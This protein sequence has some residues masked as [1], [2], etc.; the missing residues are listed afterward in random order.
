MRPESSANDVR[1][2]TVGGHRANSAGNEMHYMFPTTAGGKSGAMMCAAN[3]FD[4]EVRSI[5]L[6]EYDDTTMV[7]I[8][9]TLLQPGLDQHLVA[10]VLQPRLLLPDIYCYAATPNLPNLLTGGGDHCFT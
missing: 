2:D 7:T 10:L 4:M 1:D 6:H 9:K 3:V 8:H 5:V